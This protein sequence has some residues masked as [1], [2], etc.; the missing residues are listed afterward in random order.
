M[1]DTRNIIFTIVAL[2]PI[3]ALLIFA[4]GN[5]GNNNGLQMPAVGSVSVVNS[6]DGVTVSYPDS[7]LCEVVAGAVFPAGEYTGVAASL[8]AVVPLLD[9]Y[10][11]PASSPA[12]LVSFI[13]LVYITILEFMSLIIDFITWIPRKCRDFMRC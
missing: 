7:G 9:G 4:V 11:I 5:L 1:R 10:G 12:V 3:A 6:D 13:Y 8:L 2:L